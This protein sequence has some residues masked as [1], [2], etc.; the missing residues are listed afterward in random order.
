MI[1]DKYF[2]KK[3]IDEDMIIFALFNNPFE[4]AHYCLEC[5]EINWDLDITMINYISS[6]KILFAKPK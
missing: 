6:V 3:E 4:V 2:F 1:S 5:I